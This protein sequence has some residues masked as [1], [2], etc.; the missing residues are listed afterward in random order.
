MFGSAYPL[1]PIGRAIAEIKALPID[2]DVRH[3][4]LYEN[5]RRFL[6]LPAAAAAA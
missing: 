5:A 4:W 2:D 6:R 1:G 3:L